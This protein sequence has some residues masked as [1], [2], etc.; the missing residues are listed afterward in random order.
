MGRKKT[1]KKGDW[2]PVRVRPEWLDQ[3]RAA[4]KKNKRHAL[5]FDPDTVSEPKLLEFA[6][7]IA[8]WVTSDE[9]HKQLKPA[10][11]KAV[12]DAA[13]RVAAHFGGKIVTN[14]DGSLTVIDPGQ[15]HTITVP[16]PVALQRPKFIH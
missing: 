11:D 7:D 1:S 5:P 13:T 3:V 14:A 4:C 6:C 10:M 2:K 9:F 16:A 12:L 8:A 15:H